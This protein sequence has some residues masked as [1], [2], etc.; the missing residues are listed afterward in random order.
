M[1]IPTQK[2]AGTDFAQFTPT[3]IFHPKKCPPNWLQTKHLEPTP[4][5]TA[6][7]NYA[8]GYLLLCFNRRR[9][10]KLKKSRINIKRPRLISLRAD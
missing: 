9:F 1:N 4:T 8:H 6:N 7:R 10:K 2:T 3:R 5:E